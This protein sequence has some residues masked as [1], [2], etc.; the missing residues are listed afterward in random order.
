MTFVCD[1]VKALKLQEYFSE[2]NR[3][4]TFGNNKLLDFN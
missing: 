3:N 2:N 1:F 4:E